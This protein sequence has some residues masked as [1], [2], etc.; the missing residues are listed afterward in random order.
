MKEMIFL[1]DE[2]CWCCCERII[3]DE[4]AYVINDRLLCFHCRQV[5]D[6]GLEDVG[7]K[8]LCV[9]NWRLRRSLEFDNF[10]VTPLS[11]TKILGAIVDI[12]FRRD[13]ASFIPL[14]LLL[15]GSTLGTLEINLFSP[16]GEAWAASQKMREFLEKDIFPKFMERLI[17]GEVSDGH[18]E[19]AMWSK[20]YAQRDATG[21][22]HRN[23]SE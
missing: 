7:G 10:I 19:R 1:P 5:A 13:N 11:K 17:Q 16:R 4:I 22:Q 15:G 9:R 2:I 8:V 21:N 3:R 20:V 6:S 12:Y 18:L 14:K 23:S